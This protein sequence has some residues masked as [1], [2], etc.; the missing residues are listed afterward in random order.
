[1][2]QKLSEKDFELKKMIA[3]LESRMMNR[4]FEKVQFKDNV[5]LRG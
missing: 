1:M 5:Q 3:E 4:T 2:N